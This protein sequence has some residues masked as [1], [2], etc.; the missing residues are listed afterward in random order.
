[1]KFAIKRS[2]SIRVEGTTRNIR[3]GLLPPAAIE[4]EDPPVFLTTMLDALSS[5]ADALATI[6]AI[7]QLF[8]EVECAQIRNV[9]GDL[10]KL[11]VIGPELS[12][13][14]YHRH[15]LYFDLLGVAPETYAS[16]ARKKV[17]LIGT[18]GIGSTCAMLLGAAGVGNLVISDGDAVEE[19]NLTRSI[20]FEESDVGV[21]KVAA[22]RSRLLARNHAMSVETVPCEFNGPEMLLAAFRGCDVWILSAD[23]PADVRRWTNAAALELGIPYV[24]AG[25][26]ETLGVVGPFTIP[27]VTACLS[28][29]VL[30]GLASHEPHQE[31]NRR[32]QA[33]SYGPLN[34]LVSSITV[35]E[36]LRYLLGLE[37]RT[38]GRRLTVNSTSYD[39]SFVDVPARND[40]DCGGAPP[41][42][43]ARDRFGDLAENYRR[44]RETSSLN[45]YVLDSVVTDLVCCGEGLRIIDVGCGI[46]TLS[47]EFAS[48]GHHVT[49]I[50]ASPG[51]LAELRS[52]L[53]E[54]LLPRVSI[55]EGDAIDVVWGGHFDRVLLNLVL[56]HVA[57]PGPLL[58]KARLSLA[59]G[60]YAIIVVP[61]PIK[62]AGTWQKERVGNQ[63]EY[64]H[65]AIDDY[66]HE[67]SVAKSREDDRGEVVI[68]HVHSHRRTI[69]TY[70][71]ML[72]A[73]GFV[74]E[75]M[76]EPRPTEISSSVNYSK[77]SR[78][79]YFLV[80][81]CSAAAA[82]AAKLGG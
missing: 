4:I 39:T 77:T 65:L 9:F 10:L 76:W 66:F 26:V 55:L 57:T 61:H 62:D 81:R 28:C 18:G 14:R 30:G 19:S 25:Y 71:K 68:K 8:P 49:A 59:P 54:A 56:D 41:G 51:M 72:I 58:A 70:F 11:G 31:L 50:D 64:R 12:E 40:C 38:K 79:P 24:N 48:R 15:Q 43:H 80:F 52:R 53:P 60:G 27:K 17:G 82:A 20:L 73:A 6:D 34:C 33:P 3:I 23:I 67:G 1:V 22:A 35:N 29:A 74:V 45:A 2:L 21:V 13:G 36:V 47:V 42:L 46:G 5:P 37:P 75:D 63:W 69:A 7:A 16:L 78:V 32:L 44:F